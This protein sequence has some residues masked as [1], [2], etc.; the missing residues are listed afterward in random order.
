VEF[1]I[2]PGKQGIPMRRVAADGGR[3]SVHELGGSIRWLGLGAAL[4]FLVGLAAVDGQAQS[5]KQSYTSAVA[6]P[7]SD[8]KADDKK[9]EDE[10]KE[11][12]KP[13]V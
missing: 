10:K 4:A 2:T 6:P 1:L 8:K 12:K 7:V 3:S 5:G 13:A 11:E 9:Q